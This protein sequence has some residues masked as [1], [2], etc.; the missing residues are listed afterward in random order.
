MF[1]SR[2]SAGGVEQL[3]FPQN[4]RISSWSYDMAGHARNVWSNIVRRRIGR[5]SISTK[6]LLHASMTTTFTEEEM[7]SV[8]CMLPNLF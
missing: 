1:E 5:L 2:N 8:T 7:K 4:L 6:Y 3:P